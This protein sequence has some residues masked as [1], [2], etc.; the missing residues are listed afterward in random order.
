VTEPARSAPLPA[1]ADGL[2]R[3]LRALAARIEE[4]AAAARDAGE[5]IRSEVA[6]HDAEWSAEP[7]GRERR[8]MV[9]ELSETVVERVGEIARGYEKLSQTLEQS[10]RRL[11]EET[12]GD[13]VE[14]AEAR[15]AA[16]AR[17]PAEAP[18]ETSAGRISAGLRLLTTRMAAAGEGRARIERRLRDEFGVEDPPRVVDEL[19]GD[20]FDAG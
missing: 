18:I 9:A 3:L 16:R 10:A 1:Q 2:T 11:S 7:R 19:L 13:T 4:A 17:T 12:D 8:R 6:A 15:F 5:A 14:D 20:D